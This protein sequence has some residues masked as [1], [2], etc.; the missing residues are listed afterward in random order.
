MIGSSLLFFPFMAF[1]I[2][3][4]LLIGLALFAFWVWMIVDCAKRK[5][6]YDGEKIVWLL[7]IVF[8]SWVGALVYFIVIRMNN[9]DGV[10]K[11]K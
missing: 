1:F 3:F 4:F 7:V 9:H 5:F 6:K 11:S 10:Y 8:V 2:L